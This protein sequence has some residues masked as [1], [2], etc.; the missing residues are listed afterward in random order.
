MRGY[1][2]GLY[3]GLAE[4]TYLKIHNLKNHFW[5]AMLIHSS[6]TFLMQSYNLSQ[7]TDNPYVKMLNLKKIY[8]CL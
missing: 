5:E 1:H 2:G 3:A 6:D 4:S 8:Y 7:N